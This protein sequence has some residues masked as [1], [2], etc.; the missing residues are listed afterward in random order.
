LKDTANLSTGGSAV[1]V[2]DEV[3]PENILLAERAAGI[4]V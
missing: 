3:H 4:W 1:D 2:T